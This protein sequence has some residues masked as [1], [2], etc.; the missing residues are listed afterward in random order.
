M[1]NQLRELFNISGKECLVIVRDDVEEYSL[2]LDTLR[3]WVLQD[4]KLNLDITNI[5][6]TSDANKPLSEAQLLAFSAIQ[7]NIITSNN[8][9]I[10]NLMNRL[11]YLE[12]QHK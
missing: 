10:N 8:V 4:L 1:K 3:S 6:N 7:D 11:D 9:L 2:R 12:S 5:D